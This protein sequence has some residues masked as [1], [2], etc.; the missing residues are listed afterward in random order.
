MP[1]KEALIF[2]IINYIGEECE[3]ASFGSSVLHLRSH[4]AEQWGIM[5]CIMNRSFLAMYLIALDM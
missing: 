1:M 4:G 5:G 3:A 2:P